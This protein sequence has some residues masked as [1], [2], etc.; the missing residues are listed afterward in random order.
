MVRTNQPSTG[1]P[2]SVFISH[3]QTYRYT[4]TD[5]PVSCPPLQS[6][7]SILRVCPIEAY[8]S[9]VGLHATLLP[10]PSFALDGH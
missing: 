3:V 1:I 4:L 10:F 5:Q 9:L 6:D 7:R 8:P 2:A